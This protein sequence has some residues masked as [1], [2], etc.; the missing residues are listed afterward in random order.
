M[1]KITTLVLLLL[2]LSGCGQLYPTTDSIE[3]L[4]SEP[5]RHINTFEVSQPDFDSQLLATAMFEKL[6]V[7]GNTYKYN[8]AEIIIDVQCLDDEAISSVNVSIDTPKPLQN[9]QY[10]FEIHQALKELVNILALN[11]YQFNLI[12]DILT[13]RTIKEFN[14]GKAVKLSET[15]VA[16]SSIQQYNDETFSY[17]IVFNPIYP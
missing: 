10:A 13:I 14:E 2:L 16:A 8:N 5:F 7:E 6:P 12:E 15:V 17:T 9:Q 1:K 3:I 4:R 11:T